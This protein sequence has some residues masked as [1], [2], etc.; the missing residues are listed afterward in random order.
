MEA[1]AGAA[2]CR[3][4]AA[5]V[6]KAMAD[7]NCWN[8]SQ[9]LAQ[10]LA[11]VATAMPRREGDAL[12]GQAAMTITQAMTK[13]RNP[14]LVMSLLGGLTV[15]APRLEPKEAGQAADL[16]VR[17]LMTAELECALYLTHG[18]VV[19]TARMDAE[20]A[21]AIRGRAAAVLHQQT[22]GLSA[23]STMASIL[24]SAGKVKMEPQVARQL[25]MDS[26]RAL[27]EAKMPAHDPKARKDLSVIENWGNQRDLFAIRLQVAGLLMAADSLGRKEAAEVASAI[28]AALR[29]STDPPAL[30]GLA[31]GLSAVVTHM[32]P[33]EAADSLLQAIGMTRDSV[34]LERLARGLAA[35][36][37]RLAP[38]EAAA[39]AS[40]GAAVIAQAMRSPANQH[41][42]SQ[43]AHGLA[44]LAACMGPDQA[45][46]VSAAAAATLTK[47]MHGT[48]GFTEHIGSRPGAFLALAQALSAVAAR[49]G[50]R[51]A[52]AFAAALHA[53][54]NEGDHSNHLPPLAQCL[55]ALAGRMEPFEG[56]ALL[57]RA[58]TKTTDAAALEHLTRGLSSLATRLDPE[59]AQQIAATLDLAMSKTTNPYALSYLAQGRCALAHMKL[60]GTQQS[61]AALSLAMASYPQSPVLSQG[62]SAVL[63]RPDP[64]QLERSRHGVIGVVGVLN[65]PMTGLAATALLQSNLQPLPAQTLVELLK[66]PFCVGESR[67]LV[68]QELGLHYRRHF[69]D[70]WDFVRFSEEQKLGFDLTTSPTRLESPGPAR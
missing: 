18:L 37:A 48:K 44:E 58:M 22:K 38:A 40:K 16:L 10:S 41:G 4:I 27:G 67:R 36:A 13:A 12:L 59:D 51:D 26:A 6:L 50:A 49:L 31:D 9:N 3:Q 33:K 70:Q 60:R 29:K 39:V 56:A 61:A 69:I 66:N 20:T 30:S 54:M 65:Q 47:A 24:S 25:A 35:Q 62:L 2:A 14:Q 42:L 34:A 55:A 52:S 68:L 19:V 64:W 28:I 53:A 23:T 11:A 32:D 57:A 63:L 5:E 21:A 15:A 7:P 17:A 45:A 1:K 43:L 46:I 8:A